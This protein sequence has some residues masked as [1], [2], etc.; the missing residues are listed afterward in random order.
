MTLAC[1]ILF[2]AACSESSKVEFLFNFNVYCQAGITQSLVSSF[3]AMNSICKVFLSNLCVSS[4][5]TIF[6]HEM[7]F[8]HELPRLDE[9]TP[10]VIKSEE[11]DFSLKGYQLARVFHSN[12]TN[13]VLNTKLSL[14]EE[15]DLSSVVTANV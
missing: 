8:K 13:T 9:A 10:A 14:K 3:N 6:T 12:I 4:S 11:L 1:V 2:P 7:E 15:S 5:K